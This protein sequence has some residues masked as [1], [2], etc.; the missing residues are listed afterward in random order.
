MRAIRLVIF[1]KRNYTNFMAYITKSDISKYMLQDIDASFDTFVTFIIDSVTTYINSYCNVNFE[2]TTPATRYFDGYGGD[3]LHIGDFQPGTLTSVQILDISG[4]VIITLTLNQDYAE[5]PYNETYPN[6]LRLL[7]GGSTR[8]FWPT[9]TRAIKITGKFGHDTVPA[10][11]KIA[12]LKLSKKL[13]EDGIKGGQASREQLGSYEVLYKEINEA[14][15]A[16]GIIDILDGYR[17]VSLI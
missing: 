17:Q 8:Q 16:M 7:Q 14:T 13:L 4:T 3:L 12:A 2:N 11:I 9:Y 1:I 10:D 6:A 15:E 5:F